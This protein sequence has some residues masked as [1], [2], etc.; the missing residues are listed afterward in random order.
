MFISKKKHEEILRRETQKGMNGIKNAERLALSVPI[1]IEF[2]DVEL[3]TYEF[4]V[5]FLD[6]SRIA[7][8]ETP[9]VWQGIQN[10]AKIE[11]YNH[12]DRL[13]I[14]DLHIKRSTVQSIREKVKSTKMVK[15]VK[16][17]QGSNSIYEK[18]ED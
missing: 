8:S 17:T 11:D 5:T 9:N 4:T 10:S 14:G 3:K 1:K 6:G 2:V 13:I 15:Y 12:T 16:V 18:V 7:T